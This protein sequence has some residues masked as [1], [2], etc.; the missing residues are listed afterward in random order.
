MAYPEVDVRQWFKRV[1]HQALA[2]EPCV[3]GLGTSNRCST[4]F[5]EPPSDFKGAYW[6]I[7]LAS[8]QKPIRRRETARQEG[9]TGYGINHGID[10]RSA[11]PFEPIV[12]ERPIKSEYVDSYGHSVDLC[13]RALVDLS[14]QPKRLIV[15]AS[16]NKR[17]RRKRTYQCHEERSIGTTQGGE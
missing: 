16:R 2:A 5:R 7:A 11:D 14:A 17:R 9:S 15:V 6:C 4:P 10:G 12:V 13:R 1:R 8:S 3:E